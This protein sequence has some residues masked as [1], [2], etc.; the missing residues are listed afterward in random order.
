VSPKESNKADIERLL[1]DCR[2]R[3]NEA[4]GRGQIA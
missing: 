3:L 4:A 1:I 2:R